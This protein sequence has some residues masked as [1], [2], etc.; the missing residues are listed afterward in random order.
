MPRRR[1]VRLSDAHDYDREADRPTTL[2]FH[3][4]AEREERGFSRD[5]YEEQKPP[6][7]GAK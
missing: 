2:L 7:H 4:S 3:N 5:F 1:F 6:H